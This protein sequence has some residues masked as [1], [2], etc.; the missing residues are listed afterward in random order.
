MKKPL[1]ILFAVATISFLILPMTHEAHA[2]SAEFSS[3]KTEFTGNGK[4]LDIV[5]D[6]K[7]D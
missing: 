7:N 2:Q 1:S 6:G 5:N 4:C 3:L